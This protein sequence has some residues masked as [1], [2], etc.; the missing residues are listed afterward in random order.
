MAYHLN[1]MP[2]HTKLIHMN[3]TLLDFLFDKNFEKHTRLD[4]CKLG[5]GVPYML[6]SRHVG[7]NDFLLG[8]NAMARPFKWEFQVVESMIF[9][10]KSFPRC[11]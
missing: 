2:E 4:S 8:K 11:S 1:L 3:N 10:L 7:D 9:Q 6:H 5:V